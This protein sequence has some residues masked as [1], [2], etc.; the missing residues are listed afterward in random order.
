[1]PGLEGISTGSSSVRSTKETNLQKLIGVGSQ[2]NNIWTG[3]LETSQQV[4]VI[5]DSQ[6]QELK[7]NFHPINKPGF[8]SMNQNAQFEE[9]QR[10]E[11]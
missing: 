7:I 8:H 1:L 3:C 4:Q 11:K 2:Y 9:R 10:F 5:S 6:I